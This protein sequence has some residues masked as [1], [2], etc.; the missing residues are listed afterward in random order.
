MPT[1]LS[2]AGVLVVVDFPD[3]EADRRAVG[4]LRCEDAEPTL[5][6][7]EAPR[8]R[9]PQASAAPSRRAAASPP[10]SAP[11]GT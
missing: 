3:L 5:R 7:A 9:G 4:E 8:C 10:L 6:A 1:F 11:A 2:L